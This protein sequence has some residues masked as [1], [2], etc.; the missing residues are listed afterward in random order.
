MTLPSLTKLLLKAK[1]EK[2]LSFEDLG[3]LINRDEVW[4]ASLFYGQATAS[5]EEATSLIAA[6]DLA[7]DLKGDLSTPPVKGCLD[8]VIPT[9]PLI[10]RFYEIMQVY[11]LPMKDVIQEKFGDGIM[12]AIDFSIE[13]DKVEDPKGDRVLVKMCGKFLPYKKW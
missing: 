12:S 6:L 3:N 1:K 11:G 9:D 7:S 10:Y 4:V 8:P 5:V 2:N 13:V